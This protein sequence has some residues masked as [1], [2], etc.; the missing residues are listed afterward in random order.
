MDGGKTWQVVRERARRLDLQDRGRP[1]AQRQRPA[2]RLRRDGR[3]TGEGTPTGGLFRSLD[4]GTTWSL[5]ASGNATDILLDPNSKSPT[6]GNLDSL[7]VAFS[8]PIA[9]TN[10]PPYLYTGPVGV[11]VS[12]NQ[13]QTLQPYTGELGKN[14]LLVTPG[15]P[16][17]PIPVANSTTVTP[18]NVNS[19]YIVLAKPALTGNTAENLTTRAGSSPP[20]RTPTAPST[21]S[22]SP[23]TPARTG[24]WSSSPTSPVPAR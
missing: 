16:A 13:G 19:A 10:N 11:Y 21:A 1:L 2:H 7:Y 12:T 6:T 17:T 3:R 9:F 15:F 4:A 23:R 22:T 20:S 14:P 8:N 5:L 18:N 24:P